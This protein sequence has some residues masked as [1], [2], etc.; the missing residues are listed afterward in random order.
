MLKYTEN[1]LKIQ[2]KYDQNIMKNITKKLRLI[3]FIVKN[4]IE[5]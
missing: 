1:T 3:K 2:P 4:T 5:L